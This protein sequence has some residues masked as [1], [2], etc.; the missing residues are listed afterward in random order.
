MARRKKVLDD[1]LSDEAQMPEEAKAQSEAVASESVE[2]KEP[3]KDVKQKQVKPAQG[4][5]I[6]G[7][8][9]KLS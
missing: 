6:P 8:Y 3:S 7:K 2:A 9:R 1:V 5:K 4:V